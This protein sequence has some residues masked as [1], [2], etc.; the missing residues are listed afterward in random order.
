V[1]STLPENFFQ[2]QTSVACYHDALQ[3]GENVVDFCEIN[4]WLKNACSFKHKKLDGN[5]GAIMVVHIKD[6]FCYKIL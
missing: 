5:S 1:S 2:D 4:H 6:W 3:K